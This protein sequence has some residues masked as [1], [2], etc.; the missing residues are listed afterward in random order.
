MNE[1]EKVVMELTDAIA[2]YLGKIRTTIVLNSEVGWK[3]KL[4][5]ADLLAKQNYRKVVMCK[6]C[7]Y[8]CGNIESGRYFCERTPHRQIVEPTFYCGG[9]KEKGVKNE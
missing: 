5:I 9:G 1:N 7:E 2:E 6:N 3:H 4:A 8:V